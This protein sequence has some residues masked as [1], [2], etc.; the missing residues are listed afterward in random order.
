MKAD[1]FLL[2][3]EDTDQETSTPENERVIIE[4]LQWLG[5]DWDGEIKRQ[6]E[7]KQRHIQEA[8][9]LLEEGHAYRCRCT[10]EELERKRNAAEAEWPCPQIRWRCRDKNYPDDGTPFC[11]RLRV[12][13]EGE[14]QF[15]DRIKGD[16]SIKN[17]EIDD[18][19]I[20]R[21]NGSP[22]Y[23]FAVV[24]DDHDMGIT[25][26]IRGDGHLVYTVPQIL[27]YKALGYSTP[28]FA[29]LPLVLA[30]DK[31]PL[32]KRRGAMA[33][34]QYREEGY[35]SDA[36]IN[37]MARLG[38]GH[39]DQEYSH[40]K[41]S[42]RNSPLE[43]VQTA[44]AAYDPKKMEWLNCRAYPANESD[45]LNSLFAGELA[46]QG[47][48]DEARTSQ[49]DFLKWLS[50][51]TASI[52]ERS[53]TMV[54]MVEKSAFVFRDT[55]EYEE[56]AVKKELKAHARGVFEDMLAAIDAFES[57]TPS[58]EE[59]DA[60]IA[61]IMEQRELNMRKVA[62]PLRVGL[63]GGTVSPPIDAVMVTLGK[64][65]VKERL[66]KALEMVSNE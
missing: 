64:E 51:L 62:Q 22:I 60:V 58:A 13:Q 54:E 37:Y 61:K 12:P 45:H 56:K 2:R 10:P 39:G 19:I 6:S 63:T 21:T 20:V 3:I 66:T 65:K 5:L 50:S 30:Q 9:R 24:V 46:K 57:E 27:L 26:V 14:T 59:W 8:N 35:L 16:I 32:A 25:D 4:T 38:W 47:I 15:A 1:V 34:L 42:L 31:K 7:H 55:V 44:S 36:V 48:I 28:R 33:V 40:E 18:L 43:A 41:N 11:V 53:K 29:H 52:Q 17:S 23:N 49:P